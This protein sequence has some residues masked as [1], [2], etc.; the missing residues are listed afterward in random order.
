M[1]AINLSAGNIIIPFDKLPIEL[2]GRVYKNLMVVAR[3]LTPDELDRVLRIN[4]YDKYT[5]DELIE[6]VFK[7][8]VITIPGI[9]RN[10]N[11]DNSSAGLIT[12]VGAIILSKSMEYIDD[13]IAAHN[14]TLQNIGLLDTMAAT[15]SR[16]LS[17]PYYEVKK[18]PVNKIYEMYAVCTKVFPNEV[19]NL[20]RQEE[21]ENPG[22][23]P[24]EAF[25]NNGA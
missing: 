24:P 13:P 23:V 21:E 22:G 1:N 4:T 2:D 14:K 19:A 10:I 16:F 17:T 11:L 3:L 20:E 15:V 9:D 25:K 5:T 7:T 8:C 12:T 6:D 18:M